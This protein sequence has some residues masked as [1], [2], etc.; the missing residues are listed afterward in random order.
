MGQNRGKISLTG[1]SVGLSVVL[2]V[3]CV[4]ESSIKSGRPGCP[5]LWCLAEL[6]LSFGRAL[7]PSEGASLC[8]GFA[9]LLPAL[10]AGPKRRCSLQ[11][12]ASLV[13]FAQ[14]RLPLARTGRALSRVA[15]NRAARAELVRARR[16]SKAL[17][18]RRLG[19]ADKCSHTS[20]TRLAAQRARQ[21]NAPTQCANR[22]TQCTPQTL[23]PRG[24]E[25]FCAS[26]GPIC[27]QRRPIGP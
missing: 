20:R 2:C 6:W 25:K 21:H 3:F 17:E 11:C 24:G 14:G 16:S 13:Q 19:L 1:R 7:W 10:R 12:G 4:K 15:R 9:L 22:C 26:S 8:S 23:G 27:A 5:W 18:P